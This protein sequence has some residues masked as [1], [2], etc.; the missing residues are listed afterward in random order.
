ML[1]KYKKIFCDLF[2]SVGAMALMNVVLQFAVYPLV[3]KTLGEKIFGEM[4]FWLGIVSVLAPSFG[5]A[6]N[7]ARLVFPA[8]DS[9]KNGDYDC[10]LLFF[11]FISFAVTATIAIAQRYPVGYVLV[12][13]Y[14][15][16]ISV[17][18]NYST[19]EYRLSLNYKKQFVFYGILSAGYLMGALLCVWIQNWFWIFI[20]GETFAVAYLSLIHI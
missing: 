12:L 19:V 6:V 3:N 15:V 1:K 14:I 11:S 17:F 20:L 7:N 18:R 16:I 2:Y 5:T 4:L 8:R 9:V 10:V 13:G